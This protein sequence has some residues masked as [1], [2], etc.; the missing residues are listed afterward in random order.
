MAVYLYQDID[1]EEFWNRPS[2]KQ[3]FKPW[4]DVFF[5]ENRQVAMIFLSSNHELYSTRPVNESQVGLKHA[6]QGFVIES[7]EWYHN[8]IEDLGI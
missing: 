8:D 1:L 5:K 2:T 4:T 6:R 7:P 3:Q